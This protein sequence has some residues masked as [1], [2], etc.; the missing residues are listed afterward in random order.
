MRD[1]LVVKVRD[2]VEVYGEKIFGSKEEFDKV[3][4]I[5][6]SRITYLLQV[7][8]QINVQQMNL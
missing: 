8:Y 4:V 6:S 3:R 7:H 5:K 2:F 1:S